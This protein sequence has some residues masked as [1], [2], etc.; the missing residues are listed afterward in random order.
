VAA[1]PVAAH[2]VLFFIDK[3]P[4]R[5][6]GAV[7]VVPTVVG[8]ALT[9]QRKRLYQFVVRYDPSQLGSVDATM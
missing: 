2:V 8:P 6:A 5:V 3:E 1:V 4:V 9:D 7:R